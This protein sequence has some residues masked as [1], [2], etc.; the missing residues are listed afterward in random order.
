M[1]GRQQ[2]RDVALERF[3]EGVKDGDAR[4]LDARGRQRRRPDDIARAVDVRHFGGLKM[5]ADLDETAFAG[6][7][8][9]GG[10]VERRGV[11]AASGAN[12]H[13]VTRERGARGQRED[14]VAGPG[15]IALHDLFL[16][17]KAHA[18][19]GHGVGQATGDFRIE[20][21]HQRV[22]AVHQMHFGAQRGERAGVFAADHAA[23]DHDEL[24]RQRLEFEDFVRVMHAVVLEGKLRRSQ[25]RRTRGDQNLLAVN[26]FFRAAHCRRSG[27]CARPRNSPRRGIWSRRATS[28]APRPAAVHCPSPV[29]RAA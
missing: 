3:T 26:Q 2:R 23:A 25:W 27:W 20:K 7:E 29:S 17:V 5:R 22:A 13:A 14:H 4:L 1:P 24:F 21:R 28:A 15:G 6:R 8:S 16:P 11:A 12:E 19:G 9:G 18:V 10:E